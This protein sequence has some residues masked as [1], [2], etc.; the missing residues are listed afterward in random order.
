MTKFFPPN[1]K[2]QN[3]LAQE[4]LEIN[5][6]YICFDQTNTDVSKQF[7]PKPH[8]CVEHLR[9]KKKVQVVPDFNAEK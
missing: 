6:T 7:N 5:V 8:Q 9:D 2:G 3:I 1:L 4:F